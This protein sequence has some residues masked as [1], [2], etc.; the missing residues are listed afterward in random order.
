MTAR[1]LRTALLILGLANLAVAAIAFLIRIV[2][3]GHQYP[4]G[5]VYFSRLA[6]AEA[7]SPEYE[8]IRERVL[9][10]TSPSFWAELVLAVTG[11]ALCMIAWKQRTPP[12]VKRESDP[13]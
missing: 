13:V 12:P 10:L 5:V 4:S 9:V 7:G 8:Q 3:F 2:R 1:W 6:G 11:I